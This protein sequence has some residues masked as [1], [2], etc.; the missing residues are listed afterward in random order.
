MHFFNVSVFEG[1]WLQ[2]TSDQRN[3]SQFGIEEI[4]RTGNYSKFD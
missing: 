3:L 1:R 4:G 2:V